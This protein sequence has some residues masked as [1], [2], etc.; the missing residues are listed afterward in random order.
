MNGLGFTAVPCLGDFWDPIR[1]YWG[2][3]AQNDCEGLVP[4]LLGFAPTK[5]QYINGSPRPEDLAP[6]TYHLDYALLSRPGNSDTQL[7]LFKDYVTNLP[8]Y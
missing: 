8:L 4:V 5:W 2:S 1:K 7:D 6:E 3:G